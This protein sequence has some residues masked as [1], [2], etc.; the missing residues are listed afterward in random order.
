[1]MIHNLKCI[2]SWYIPTCFCVQVPKRAAGKS[3]ITV[4]GERKV[5]RS[6]DACCPL[7][8]GSSHVETCTRHLG[9]GRGRG[10]SREGG[11]ECPFGWFVADKWKS[12][13]LKSSWLLTACCPLSFS[14]P[15]LPGEVLR[16]SPLVSGQWPPQ[17]SRHPREAPSPAGLSLDSCPDPAWCHPSFRAGQIACSRK[18]QIR[19]S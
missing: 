11:Q 15:S 13:P 18:I 16:T 4:G 19:H 5:R 2:S 3:L 1:M 9:R 7:L 14:I 17:W 6:Q 12:D 10:R 8:L